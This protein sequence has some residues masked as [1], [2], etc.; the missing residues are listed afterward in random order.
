MDHSDPALC[1]RPS[2]AGDEVGGPDGFQL[3]ED[4]DR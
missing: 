1:E 2:P 4:E 3:R